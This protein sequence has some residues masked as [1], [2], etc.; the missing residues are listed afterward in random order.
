LLRPELL[1]QGVLIVLAPEARLRAFVL[2][3]VSSRVDADD[4]VQEVFLRMQKSLPGL[5]EEER[6]GPWVYQL[7]RSAIADHHRQR[8]RHPLLG[9]APEEPDEKAPESAESAEELL[10]LHVAPFV[11]M[12]PSP[13]REALTLTELEGMTHRQAAD[14]LGVSLPAMKSRVLRGRTQLR[15]LLDAC[16]EIRLDTRGNVVDCE[17]R[18]SPGQ[19][20]CAC[21]PRP[22]REV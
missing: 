7:A 2:R 3:R 8:A 10:A 13:Y 14:L 21:N 1:P 4:I 12:L 5:R 19:P 11:A 17:P 16:C 20:P 15:G 18:R 22:P 6:F 9:D